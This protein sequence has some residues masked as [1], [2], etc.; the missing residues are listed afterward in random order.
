M[1]ITILKPE[2]APMH[3]YDSS[4]EEIHVDLEGDIEMAEARHGK[5]SKSL[6]AIVTPG[7]IITDDPQWMRGHGTFVTPDT[8][9][10][11]ATVA[12][13]VQKTN[14][15]LSVRPLRARYTPE[16]GDLVVGRIVEVQSKRWRV[17]VSAPLLAALPLSSINLPGGILRKRTSTDELQ[18]RTF[19]SEGDLLVA[20]V[21]SLFQDGSASL[22]TR[23]LKYG[24]LRNGV[25]LSV[26]G[27]GGGGVVRSRRQTWTI[28]TANGGGE[29]DVVLGVNGYIW[30][31]KHGAKDNPSTPVSITRLEESVSYSIYSS[32][33]DVIP[34]ATRREIARVCGCITALVE[35]SVRVDEDMVMKAY[36]ASVDL[37]LETG[38]EDAQ[39]SIDHLGGRQVG[40]KGRE[41]VRDENE[42]N[43][44]KAS[45]ILIEREYRAGLEGLTTARGAGDRSS[46]AERHGLRGG[47][48]RPNGR[49]SKTTQEHET[50][51]LWLWKQHSSAEEAPH[52]SLDTR[53][54]AIE[55]FMRRTWRCGIVLPF[56]IKVMSVNVYNSSYEAQSS[57]TRRREYLLLDLSSWEEPSV[58]NYT[59]SA[60]QG[61]DNEQ[62]A[63][64]ARPILDESKLNGSVRIFFPGKAIRFEI[65][66]MSD[67][68]YRASFG[69]SKSIIAGHIVPSS[70]GPELVDYAFPEG[71]GRRGGTS[72]PKSNDNITI[73]NAK[74]IKLDDPSKVAKYPHDNP[75]C[76]VKLILTLA[77][78]V[79]NVEGATIEEV[80][81][82]ANDE[83][84]LWKPVHSTA[85]DP[86]MGKTMLVCALIQVAS[87]SRTNWDPYKP[88]PVVCPSAIIDNWIEELTR[89]WPSLELCLYHGIDAGCPSLA[90]EVL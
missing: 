12:G 7:E 78:R 8:T 65:P 71:K 37:A 3:D 29:V 24:K 18:I 76:L 41:A 20:E 32:Q 2:P 16:I 50:L 46:P 26:S 11:I 13:T 40:Y 87:H 68:P 1:A 35:N 31:A 90:S 25:F 36:E 22:H 70:L 55:S 63:T 27:A 79:G 67:A 5:K 59:Y 48:S 30:I 4:D 75:I 64:G 21:Q 42:E 88:A 58:Q 81:Q 86:G 14:K 28:H 9:S 61:P 60:V 49:D 33:N 72:G 52:I 23:S 17:D 82:R 66:P 53:A 54:N 85:D 6:K 74:G 73:R 62:E 19:F 44:K 80:L 89:N 15:L 43:K 56:S 39:G 69:C 83:A 57:Y 51:I 47:A 45:L 34:A 38:Y 84:I 10:I 77:L